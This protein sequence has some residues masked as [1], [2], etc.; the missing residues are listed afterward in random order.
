MSIIYLVLTLGPSARRL[1][2][3]GFSPWFLFL[4]LLFKPIGSIV[5]LVLFCMPTKII[6]ETKQDGEAIPNTETTSQPSDEAK[7]E[8]VKTE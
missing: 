2:D 4:H 7:Q 5:L 3:A 8:E 6:I 1:R